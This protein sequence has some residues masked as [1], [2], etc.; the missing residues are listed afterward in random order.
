M[1]VVYPE[2]PYAHELTQ[3]EMDSDK[4]MRAYRH[5]RAIRLG[6]V[7]AGILTLWSLLLVLQ[8]GPVEPHAFV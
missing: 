3:Y 7:F 8:V 1:Y 6:L 5:R 4:A 2:A